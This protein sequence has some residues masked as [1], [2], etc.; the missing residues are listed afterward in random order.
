MA[1]L[2]HGDEIVISFDL[3]GQLVPQDVDQ[4]MAGEHAGGDFPMRQALFGEE[5]Q[6]DHDQCHVVMP[7]LPASGLIVGHTA[8]ALGI[9]KGPFDEMAVGL[10]AGQSAQ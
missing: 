4:V 9:L 7:S 3:A 5:H 2:D 6:G 8:G 10:H 1:I